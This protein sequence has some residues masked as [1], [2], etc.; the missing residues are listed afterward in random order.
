MRT[1]KA[2]TVL[3]LLLSLTMVSALG[4]GVL[5]VNGE[6]LSRE[7]CNAWMW[8]VKHSYEDLVGYY[9]KTLGINYWGLTYSNGQCIWDSVKA[10]AF[11]QLVMME[12]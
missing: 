6:E 1:F 2:V 10:D 8:L 12:V 4:E 3:F 7:E 11:K 9:Q 5:T